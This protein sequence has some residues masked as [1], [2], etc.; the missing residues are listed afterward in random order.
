MAD[1][2]VEINVN[3]PET[4]VESDETEEMEPWQTA[5]LEGVSYGE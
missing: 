3:A 4:L 2:V 1:E 5:L